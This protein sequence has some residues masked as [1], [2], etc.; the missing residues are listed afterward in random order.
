[1]ERVVLVRHAL[2]A[3]NRDGMC[4]YRPP[5]EGLT[6]EGVEQARR[7]RAVL[8][9]E[10]VELGVATQLRRTQETLELALGAR[11]VPTLVVPELNEIDFGSFEGGLLDRYR[12]WAG[13]EQPTT[14]APGGGESRAGAAARFARG[15]RVVLARPERLALVVGHALVVRYVLDAAAGLPPAAR[16]APVE[17]AA[18]VRLDATEVGAAARLLEEWSVDPNFRTEEVAGASEAGRR[19][20]RRRPRA[21]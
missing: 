16:M 19:R 5:G 8:E 7:L 9:G 1:L 12:A 4:S 21:Q 14:P 11:A 18:P 3:S 2:A 13:A 10:P 17:H 15:L 6:P 20:L